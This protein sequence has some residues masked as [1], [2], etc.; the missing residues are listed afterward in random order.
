M[1]D[2]G[3]GGRRTH[4]SANG[5]PEST[6]L[7]WD[8]DCQ[9]DRRLLRVSAACFEGC[10]WFQRTPTDGKWNG[11]WGEMILHRRRETR[12]WREKYH[13]TKTKGLQKQASML[14]STR[15]SRPAYDHTEAHEAPCSGQPQCRCCVAMDECHVTGSEVRIS[16]GLREPNSGG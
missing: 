1:K 14:D 7:A 6:A 4:R 10:S 15:W 11:R 9:L 5:L 12:Q 3:V 2:F 8:V 16:A 13:R